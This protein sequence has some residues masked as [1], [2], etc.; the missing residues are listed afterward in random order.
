MSQTKITDAGL[1]EVANKLPSLT[2]LYISDVH[3]FTDAGLKEVA[4]LQNL[5]YLALSLTEITNA[6][7]KELAK[8][9]QLTYLNVVACK[10][11]TKSGVADFKKALPK[12]DILH[13]PM[14]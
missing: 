14:K 6:G 3:T 8:M 9:K 13:N 2:K 5:T 12:C 7:L 10:K 4:K 1:R 11:V